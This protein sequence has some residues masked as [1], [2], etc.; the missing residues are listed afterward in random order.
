MA[1]DLFAA[2][3]A[4]HAPLLDLDVLP[5]H[6]RG[7]GPHPADAAAALPRRAVQRTAAPLRRH[8]PHLRDPR[9]LH[10]P[11]GLEKPFKALLQGGA[12]RA[13]SQ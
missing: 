7:G 13:G 3:G 2:A 10:L 5:S 1:R 12:V 11:G 6:L 8:P 9:E 4:H